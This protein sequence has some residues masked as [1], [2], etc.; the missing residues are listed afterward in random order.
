MNHFFAQKEF[1]SQAFFYRL[2]NFQILL[3]ILTHKNTLIQL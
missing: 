1:I 3:L 2:K